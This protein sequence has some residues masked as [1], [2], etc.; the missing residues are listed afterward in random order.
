MHFSYSE[1]HLPIRY[2][3]P[4]FLRGLIKVIPVYVSF[5]LQVKHLAEL[6]QQSLSPFLKK[7][8]LR[9]IGCRPLLPTVSA[10]YR[11]AVPVG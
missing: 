9:L 6:L 7:S 4:R 10:H 8:L 1:P 3:L 5:G 2:S 11:L